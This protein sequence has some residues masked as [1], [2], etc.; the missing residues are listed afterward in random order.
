MAGSPKR[1]QRRAEE[2]GKPEASNTGLTLAGPKVPEHQWRTFS[3]TEKIIATLGGNL[4]NI[5]KI[6][7]IEEPD[8]HDKS[9]QVRIF[10]IGIKLGLKL[11]AQQHRSA[12]EQ[13]ILA[14]IAEAFRVKQRG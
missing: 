7:D 12:A 13:A 11:H 5:R 8:M 14:R 9:L 6:V 3:D 10:E 2:A 4:D 1:R